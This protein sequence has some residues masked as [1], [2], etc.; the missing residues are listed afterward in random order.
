MGR[1]G[2]TR[3]VVYDDSCVTY[4]APMI[5]DP[6]F[7]LCAIP[8]VLL[9]GMAKG[10][11]GGAVSVVAVPLMTLAVPPVQAAAVLLPLLVAMDMVALWSFRGTWSKANIRIVLPGAIGGIV[12]GALAFHRLS[13]D[14]IRL[15]IGL[16]AIAFCLNHWLRP[17]S[18]ETKPPGVPA[19]VFW[20][21]VSGFTSFGIHQ[22]G[23]PISV[24][25]LPQRMDKQT[26]MGTFAVFF[27]VVNL[28]K[29]IPY[30]WLGQFSTGNLLT[31]LVLLPLAPVGVRLGY[32]ALQRISQALVY[33][34]CYGFLMV[35]GLKL[36][37]DGVVG[38]LP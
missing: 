14:A 28:V 27:T 10:G 7:Y 16:I 5:T 6:F 12:I 13:D 33:R 26:L 9:Y 18:T 34:I 29:L 36:F 25:L 31:S 21:A 11:L 20:G 2:N 17:G 32:C 35:V 1:R 37:W 24:Y 38:V 15:L 22:G 8:A 4:A 23:P 30:T 3:F 19:G